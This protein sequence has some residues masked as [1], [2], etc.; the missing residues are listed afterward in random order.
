MPTHWTGTTEQRYARLE[1]DDR[2]CDGNNRRC[3]RGA[4]ERYTLAPAQDWT[5]IPDASPVEKL[6]CSRHRQQFINNPT[7]VV[8]K[9]DRFPA[10]LR[11]V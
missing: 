5:A 2:R 7:Y 3:P 11:D 6:S 10:L 1:R 4:V 8:I 9:M